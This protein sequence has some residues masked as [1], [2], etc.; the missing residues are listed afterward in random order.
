MKKVKKV[1]WITIKDPTGL[2][3]AKILEITKDPRGKTAFV[4]T[5]IDE[6]LDSHKKVKL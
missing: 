3:S 1:P 4:L 5:A 6:K 2:R